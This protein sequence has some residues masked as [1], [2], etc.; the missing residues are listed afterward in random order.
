MVEV[1]A[2]LGILVVVRLEVLCKMLDTKK[3]S[4]S[5]PGDST[6]AHDSLA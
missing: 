1:D 5:A 6:V 2:V 4:A 3:S